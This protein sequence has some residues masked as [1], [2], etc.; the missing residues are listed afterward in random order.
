M[1]IKSI[2]PSWEGRIT[3]GEK[4]V[5]KRRVEIFFGLRPGEF[6]VFTDGKDWK[7]QFQKL[8]LTDSNPNQKPQSPKPFSR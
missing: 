5:S 3:L 7:V 2:N 4:E 1:K 8:I 6:V